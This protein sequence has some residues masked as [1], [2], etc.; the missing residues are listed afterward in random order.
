MLLLSAPSSPGMG[1]KDSREAGTLPR[2]ALYTRGF[3]TRVHVRIR[4]PLHPSLT[5]QTSEGE[6]TEREEEGER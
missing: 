6:Q 1:K 4:S 5:E 2:S 3:C